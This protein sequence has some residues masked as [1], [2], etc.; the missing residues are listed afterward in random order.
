MK[1]YQQIAVIAALVVVLVAG[2]A[3]ISGFRHTLKPVAAAPAPDR[4][5]V[6]VVTMECSYPQAQTTGPVVAA[7]TQST[8]G[9]YTLPAGQADCTNGLQSLYAQGL[10]LQSFGVIQQT[11]QTFSDT[12]AA[13]SSVT[14]T[15]TT[16]QYLQWVLVGHHWGM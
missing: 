11:S 9:S 16:A 6:V 7:V 15:F 14:T 8:N 1:S 5:E 13:N 2:I 3:A 4:A 12:S 10:D